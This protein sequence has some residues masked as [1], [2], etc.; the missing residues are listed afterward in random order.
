MSNALT[1][2]PSPSDASTMPAAPAADRP[3]RPEP[4]RRRRT[5]LGRVLRM[6]RFEFAMILR[7]RVAVLSIALAPL[8]AIGMVFMDRPATPA[9]WLVMLSS[10]SVLVLIV[11]VYNTTTST[12]VARR[13]TQVLKRLR[14]SELLPR[15]MLISLA[16]PYVVV[17]TLQVLVVAIVYQ[18]LGGPAAFTPGFALVVL[19]TALLGVLGGF[20]TA[21]MA[22]TSERVQFAVLPI[23]L[24]G[25]VGAMFVLNPAASDDLRAVALLV[26]FAASSD[27]AARAL[28]APGEFVVAPSVMT[29]LAERVDVPASVLMTGVD[30]ALIALWCVVFAAVARRNWRWEPRG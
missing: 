10:M 26:P 3:V 5:A 7:Q 23:L 1:S 8:I 9:A 11:A 20:A 22:A 19:A 12:V 2:R 30:I 21:G 6:T 17:G 14:T 29:D 28:G 16:L 13:E 18:L 24:I 15:Q 4:R 25:L 27:L